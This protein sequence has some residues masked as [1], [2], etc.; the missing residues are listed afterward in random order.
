MKR[1]AA[2]RTKKFVKPNMVIFQRNN[3]PRCNLVRRLETSKDNLYLRPLI[4]TYFIRLFEISKC[5]IKRTYEDEAEE[6]GHGK[7]V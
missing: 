2:S 1:L 4:K 6:S 5:I 3:Y 7:A